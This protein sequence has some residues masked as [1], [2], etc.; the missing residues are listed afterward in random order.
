[1]LE[2]IIF[3]T[4]IQIFLKNP[5]YIFLIAEFPHNYKFTV[6]PSVQFLIISTNS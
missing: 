5:S 3:L 4:E 2:T 1:M 6:I